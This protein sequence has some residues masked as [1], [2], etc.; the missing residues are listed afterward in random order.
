VAWAVA[1]GVGDAD[2]NSDGLAEA[3]VR[4]PADVAASFAGERFT[5]V[6]AMASKTKTQTAVRIR[7]PRLMPS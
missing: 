2:G 1:V 7:R 5:T 3:V 6:A 4:T